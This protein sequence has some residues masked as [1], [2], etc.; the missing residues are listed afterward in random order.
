MYLKQAVLRSKIKGYSLMEMMV[1]VGLMGIIMG[2]AAPSLADFVKSNRLTTVSNKLVSAI[3]LARNEA[4]NS[5]A[6]VTISFPGG[7]WNVASIPLTTTTPV[8]IA[9]Y[10]LDTGTNLTF[11]NNAINSITF[12][13]DGFRDLSQATT[14]F[15]FIVCDADLDAV[16]H[17]NVTP[18]GTTSVTRSTGGCP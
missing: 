14:G 18:A 17:V 11:S 12:T 9:F 15:H 6:T 5:R 7:G 16:R 1:T 13:P 8:P 2:I 3:I 10:T 4:I